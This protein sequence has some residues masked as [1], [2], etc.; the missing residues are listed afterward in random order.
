LFASRVLGQDVGERLHVKVASAGMRVEL[1]E[2]RMPRQQAV[3][4][5]LPGEDD[6]QV[7]FRG[8]KSQSL[9]QHAGNLLG[10]RFALLLE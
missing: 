9:V 3:C 7:G 10:E 6:A 5:R 2:A 4:A 1:G 8:L